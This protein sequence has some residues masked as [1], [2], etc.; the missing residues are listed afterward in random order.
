MLGHLLAAD[1]LPKAL[2]ILLLE[3]YLGLGTTN[4]DLADKLRVFNDVLL[5]NALSTSLLRLS[6]GSLVAL[7]VLHE[8]IIIQALDKSLSVDLLSLVKLVVFQ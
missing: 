7:A 2:I 6:S 5:A 3:K 8:H 1:H 4:E